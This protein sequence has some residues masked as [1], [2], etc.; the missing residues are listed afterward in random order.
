[1]TEN[2]TNMA[3]QVSAGTKGFAVS[4][5]VTHQITA[6]LPVFLRCLVIITTTITKVPQ[7][8]STDTDTVTTLTTLTPTRVVQVTLAHLTRGP[9][10]Q[11]NR[12][13]RIIS[14]QSLTGQGTT[15][16]SIDP[17]QVHIQLHRKKFTH[18]IH[19]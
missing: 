12:T 7:I 1:M 5:G 11:A 8:T 3:R 9:I 13:D 17:T 4:C 19:E 6:H 15:L 18:Q 10:T 14:A 16:A 2:M